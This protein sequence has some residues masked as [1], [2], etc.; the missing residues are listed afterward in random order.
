M[1]LTSGGYKNFRFLVI[2]HSVVLLFAPESS[3]KSCADKLV[4]VNA[5]VIL[6]SEGAA[7]LFQ[8]GS[9]GGS[10][11]CNNPAAVILAS[12]DGG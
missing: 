2:G 11:V 6:F 1:R 4:S 8:D 5:G 7:T 10:N 3:I 12:S 9:S